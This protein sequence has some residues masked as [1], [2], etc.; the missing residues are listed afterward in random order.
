MRSLV[1]ASVSEFRTFFPHCNRLD[2]CRCFYSPP[3]HLKLDESNFQWRTR[4]QQREIRSKLIWLKFKMLFEVKPDDTGRDQK[5]PDQTQLI[6][7]LTRLHWRG[8]QI[9]DVKHFPAPT[10]RANENCKMFYRLDGKCARLWEIYDGNIIH[11]DNLTWPT[12]DT[13]CQFDSFWWAK[14]METIWKF[15]LNRKWDIQQFSRHF[16][17]FLITFFCRS[18]CYCVSKLHHTKNEFESFECHSRFLIEQ[19]FSVECPKFSRIS[20]NWGGLQITEV[21]VY[22][23]F[24]G[25]HKKNVCQLPDSAMTRHETEI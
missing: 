19:L 5:K 15:P 17:D 24:H 25:D 4:A 18:I 23:L 1:Q 6:I 8:N 13:G 3:S 16:L 14:F 10:W 20:K 12:I 22:T 21:H 9:S 11:F 2:H 7:K